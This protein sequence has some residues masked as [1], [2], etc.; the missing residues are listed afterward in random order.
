[1]EMGD[2]GM[3]FGWLGILLWIVAILAVA[4]LIKYPFTARA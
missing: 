4:A 3:G 1:M 2:G